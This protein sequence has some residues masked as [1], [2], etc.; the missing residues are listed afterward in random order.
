M[1]DS[2]LIW[3]FLTREYPDDNIVV[4]IYCCSNARTIKIAS[5]NLFNIC[6]QIFYPAMSEDLIN[7]VIKSYLDNKKVQYHKGEIKIKPIY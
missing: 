5:D 4:Y 3:N 1:S 2:E 6:K 7:N